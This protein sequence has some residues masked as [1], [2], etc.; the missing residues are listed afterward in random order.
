MKKLFYLLALAVIGNAMVAQTYSIGYGTGTSNPYIRNNNG[1]AVT[2]ILSAPS[3]SVMSAAQTIPFSFNFFGVPV[4]QYKVSDNGYLTFDASATT[5]YQSNTSIPDAGGPNN[6]IYAFWDNLRLA[7]GAGVADKVV[8]WTYGATGSRVH[9]IQWVSVTAVSGTG[10][11]IWATV[12]LYECGDFDIVL[13]A[14]NYTAGLTATIGAENATGTVGV[15]TATSPSANYPASA[16]SDVDAADDYVVSFINSTTLYDV[17]VDAIKINDF[18]P[19]GSTNITTTFTNKGSSSVSSITF[20]Y[21]IDG[22]APVSG[23]STGLSIAPGATTDVSHVTPWNATAGSHSIVVTPTQVNGNAD[24]RSC[25]NTGSE[26]TFVYD[27]TNSTTRTPLFEIFTSSTC[28]PC[29]PGNENYHSI[30]DLKPRLDFV[31]VKWQQD[32][33]GTGDPYATNE[34]VN[35]RSTY[36]GINSI[37]RMEIDG[38][39]DGNANSFT[40]ALYVAAK[41][42][43]AFATMNGTYQVDTV[44]KRVYYTINYSPTI[45]IPAN[46]VRLFTAI[47]EGL[48]T[49]NVKSNLET[50][51]IDVVKK[52]LPTETG[53]L[54]AAKT[55]G[56]TNMVKDSFTFEGTYR[57][58][59][60]G[61]SANRI[62]HTTEN[63]IEEFTDLKVVTWLQETSKFVWQAANLTFAGFL[64]G[65]A[66]GINNTISN[67][68][69][70]VYPNPASDKVMVNFELSS[71]TDL[72]VQLIDPQGKVIVSEKAQYSNGAHSMS[73]DL[74]GLSNGN[75]IIQLVG[76]TD[77]VSKQIS[78]MH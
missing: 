75:Y 49:R 53:T 38:G 60:D 21:S 73:I 47:N 14:S 50:E 62:N 51:F 67:V 61:A 35:R 7:T 45:N 57:L 42:S 37:P 6:A 41:G 8:S 20:Q 77:K 32:F 78:V 30:V 3:D 28:P 11:F 70:N 23:T 36:Y 69:L 59:A 4:T 19:A 2:T 40:D 56:S 31:S 46:A 65:N 74:G 58:P 48:T 5:S 66:T 76:N 39:W 29:K 12:R 64:P 26:N 68:N 16:T 10:T 34:S 13:D 1:G 22:G 54:L 15:Q 27:N 33:P 18:I 71:S 43:P 63:S 72:N 55:A 44:L 25:N 24:A 9:V 52:A 17:Q